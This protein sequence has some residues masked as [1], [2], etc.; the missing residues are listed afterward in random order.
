M[1]PGEHLDVGHNPLGSLSVFALLG[2]LALQVST[3][4]VA[5]DEIANVG[6]LNRFVSSD[7]AA[8]ATGWHKE[9]GQ[10]ILLA[11]VALHIGAIVFYRL[12]HRLDLVRPMITGDKALPAGTPASADGAP[13]RL[14]ALALAT[15][16]VGVVAWLVQLSP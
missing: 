11:L 13:Q 4:L 3:G 6:P 15:L 14:A 16:C 2:M 8:S 9:W 7:T 12:R 10:W 1:A 5:D